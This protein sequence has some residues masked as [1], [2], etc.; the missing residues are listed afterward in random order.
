MLLFS[1]AWSWVRSKCQL[2]GPRSI[3][4]KK[5]EVA[6]FLWRNSLWSQKEDAGGG[7]GGVGI[8]GVL[9][10]AAAATEIDGKLYHA[11]LVLAKF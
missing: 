11:P 3:G 9:F 4:P 10:L 5:E 2:L 6:V 8:A 7:V 1:W